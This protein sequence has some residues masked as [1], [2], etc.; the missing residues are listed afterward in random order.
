MFS[1]LV[2]KTLDLEL[3]PDPHWDLNPDPQSEK[4]FIRI[5]IKSMRIQN[6]G[7]YRYV[8]KKTLNQTKDAQR[9]SKLKSWP[10]S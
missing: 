10:K 8:N 5:R 3:D 2:I 4:M 7:I 6:P 1:N 9:Y